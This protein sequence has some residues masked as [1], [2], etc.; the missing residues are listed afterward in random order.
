MPKA[1]ATEVVP[2]TLS[3]P[4]TGLVVVVLEEQPLLGLLLLLLVRRWD[5]RLALLGAR[6][7]LKLA[8]L[9]LAVVELSLRLVVVEVGQ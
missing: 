2:P 6:E 1:V 8:L 5:I 3:E 7:V 9:R 4:R